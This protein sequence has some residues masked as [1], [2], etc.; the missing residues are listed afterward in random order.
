MIT[1]LLAVVSLG[2]AVAVSMSAV[3]CQRVPLLAPSG[4]TIVLNASTNVLPV[5]G[6]TTIIAQVLEAA[7]TPPHSGTHVTFT[8]SLGSF[9]PADAETD[10][11]G[12]ATVTFL[13]GN[14]SGTANITAL[15]GGASVGTNG[16]LK[17]LV[18]S[19]AVGRVNMSA[20]PTLVPATGGQSTVTATVFDVNGNA[21][22][23]AL[24][25]F[26]TTAGT[27]STSAVTTDSGG[28]AV[29]ILRTN[30]KA[31]VTGTVGAQGG[32]STT[33]PGTGTGT[34]PTTPSASGQSSGQ[35]VVDIA[36]SPTL[37][38]TPPSPAPSAGLPATFT[39][40]VTAASANGSVVRDVTVN[41]GDG[42]APQSLGAIT[43]SQT[44]SHVYA[45]PGTYI[46]SA[47]LTDASGNVVPVSTPVAVI[48]V[49]RPT[50]IITQSPSP[51]H[52]GSQTTITVQVTLPTGIGVQN[53]TIDFGDSAV[54]GCNSKASLGGATSASQPHVYTA[55][56]NYTV[57]VTVL[58][59]SNQTT[60]GTTVV[61]IAP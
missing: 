41:W 33:T 59:T 21:L 18:G 57:T 49:P 25:S 2:L 15:S 10:I 7:G 55:V 40:V 24:V 56:G 27:L 42:S 61:N 13:A 28:N 17:I 1:R 8:T 35:V 23:S 36:S 12:R 14:N 48:P 43:G 60:V 4:S 5:N 52:A 58:D 38:I 47:T 50:I 20:N 29:T 51:G 19:A 44:A 45:N 9:Q 39:F 37:V 53:T 3:A 6:S 54:C 34:T 32:S 11:G 46:V 16:A 31:T 30:T 26:T 22:P